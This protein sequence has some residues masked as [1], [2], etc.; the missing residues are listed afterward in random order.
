MAISLSAFI[1]KLL[2]AHAARAFPS[3]SPV[4]SSCTSGFT[5]CTHDGDLVVCA[6]PQAGCS[7]LMLLEPSPPRPQCAAAAPAAPLPPHAR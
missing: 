3:A 2:S 5:A 1:A 4:R 7:A 6:R